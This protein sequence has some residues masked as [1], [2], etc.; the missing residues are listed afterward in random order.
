MSSEKKTKFYAVRKGRYPGIYTTWEEAEK[1]INDGFKKP[2]HKSFLTKKEA[3][4][5]INGEDTNKKTIRFEKIEKQI[6]DLFE[7][8]EEQKKHITALNEKYDALL[9][10][11]VNF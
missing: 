6:E 8:C 7:Q 2:E 9:K 3:E 1:Q 11:I 10:C 4:K 5:Y